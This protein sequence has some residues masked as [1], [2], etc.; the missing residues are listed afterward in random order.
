MPINLENPCCLCGFRS[1]RSILKARDRSIRTEGVWEY[2][3]CDSC[4][5]VFLNP[6]PTAKELTSHY[7]KINDLDYE[8]LPIRLLMWLKK[9]QSYL[10]KKIP[11]ISGGSLL[12]VGCG[13]D[14][15]LFVQKKRGL[16]VFGIDIDKNAVVYLNSRGISSWAG[17]LTDIDFKEKKFDVI[18]FWHSFEHD[19]HPVETLNKCNKISKPNGLVIINV[20]NFVSVEKEIFGENWVYLAPPRHIYHYTCATLS[21]LAEKCGFHVEKVKYPALNPQLWSRSFMNYLEEYT[22]LQLSAIART[23][24]TLLLFPFVLPLNLL[25]ASFGKSS[26]MELHLRKCK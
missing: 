20:P 2:V 22:P 1:A 17:Q 24:F 4:G 5:L 16:D 21:Q 11:C 6:I 15:F 8:S 12:D 13:R 25:T 26:V 23:F 14:P 7:E 18:T 19:L 10:T 3:R 9:V